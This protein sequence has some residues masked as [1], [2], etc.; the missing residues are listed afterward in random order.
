[1]RGLYERG[2]RCPDVP[3]PYH[4]TPNRPFIDG[5]VLADAESASMEELEAASDILDR[6]RKESQ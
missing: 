1:V 3:C 6:V 2:C 5:T 4:P